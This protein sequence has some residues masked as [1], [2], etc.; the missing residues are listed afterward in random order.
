MYTKSR[1]CVWIPNEKPHHSPVKVVYT[2]KI[3]T[4]TACT[5]SMSIYYSRLFL[6]SKSHP[7]ALLPSFLHPKHAEMS[8]NLTKRKKKRSVKSTIH[9]SSLHEPNFIPPKYNLPVQCSTSIYI[10]PG[11]FKGWITL[12]TAL[13]TLFFSFS[14]LFGC[15]NCSRTTLLRYTS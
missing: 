3:F 8:Q 4:M 7:L 15:R 9:T 11:L 1:A 6:F 12:S 5:K 10:R 13:S 14:T 2:T